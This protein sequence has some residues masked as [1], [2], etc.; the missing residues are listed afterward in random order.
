MFYL[1]KKL[2]LYKKIKVMFKDFL[3]FTGQ[4]IYFVFISIPL[5]LLFLL[6]ANIA[7]EVKNKLHARQ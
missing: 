4:L 7:C 1:E 2:Y 3:H 6:V 5:A